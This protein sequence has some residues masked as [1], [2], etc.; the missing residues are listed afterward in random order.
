[1]M[2]QIRT[3]DVETC[4]K[5]SS[6]GFQRDYIHNAIIENQGTTS[7]HVKQFS[8]GLQR[9]YRQK[10]TNENWNRN[11]WVHFG[12]MFGSVASLACTN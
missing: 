6:L 10:D 1:M 7:T 2:L 8:L 9:G 5:Q 12:R 11:S 4:M 3:R